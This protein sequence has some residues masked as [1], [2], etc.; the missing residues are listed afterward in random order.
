[1]FF[2]LIAAI[3]KTVTLS[4]WRSDWPLHD[5]V[6]NNPHPNRSWPAGCEGVNGSD[7]GTSAGFLVAPGFSQL[8]NGGAV[9]RVEVLASR[10]DQDDARHPIRVAARVEAHNVT[11][12][13]MSDQDVGLWQSG[14][15]EKFR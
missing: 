8:R 1:M 4:Y 13:R 14:A 12:Q 11:S 5:G 2:S 9:A 3:P 6:V 15:G 10:V 7:A